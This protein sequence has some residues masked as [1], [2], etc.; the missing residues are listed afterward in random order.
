MMSQHHFYTQHNGEKTHVLMG[1]DYPLQ[2]FFLVI[3]KESDLDVPFWSNLN[4]ED[5]EEAH[6]KNL[7]S[8]LDILKKLD[9]EIPV[10]MLE[11][12]NQDKLSNVRN[13]QV[14]HKVTAIGHE[15]VER[16][17]FE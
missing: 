12:I 9:I 6:P 11:D 1:W 15:R 4:A 2:G 7:K 3:E 16:D 8:F 5:A 14:M 17:D 13:K 10:E